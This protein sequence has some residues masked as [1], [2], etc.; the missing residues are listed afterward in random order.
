MSESDQLAPEEFGP[1]TLHER[2]GVGGM[3]SVY[4]AVHRETGKVVALKRL[5]PQLA[6]DATLVKQ[7]IREGEIA[8]VI[9]HPNIVGVEDSGWVGRER[10]LAMEYVRGQSVLQLLRRANEDST[11]APVGVTIWILHEILSALDHAM[12]GLDQ[13]GKAFNVV[14]RD[15][16]PSN[17]ILTP[18]GVVKLIDFGVA[19]A[20][21]GRYATNSGRIKGKLGYMPPEVLAGRQVD[22]RSDLFSTAIVAW[23]LL[24]AQRLF[25][26]TEHEQLVSRA[27]KHQKTP[28]SSINRWVT[29]ELDALLAVALE[30]DPNDRWGSAGAMLKALAPILQSQGEGASQEAVAQWCK[31]LRIA[32]GVLEHTETNHSVPLADLLPARTPAKVVL[33]NT[34]LNIPGVRRFVEAVHTVVDA[35]FDPSERHREVTDGSVPAIPHDFGAGEQT[36]QMDPQTVSDEE[37]FQ[38][39]G[40]TDAENLTGHTVSWLPKS[41]R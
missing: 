20:L 10:Y 39:V 12:T 18:R 25:R 13:E 21:E 27:Q 2:L 41:E 5:L 34:Q 24:T 14:H 9:A 26:G 7:F 17:I 40:T 35:E 23:E 31:Q 4:R 30:E 16:S 3:A 37:E 28:P 22:Q 33:P 8:S 32:E 36:E 19:K 6:T 1:Y 29:K 11:P 38:D 15:L